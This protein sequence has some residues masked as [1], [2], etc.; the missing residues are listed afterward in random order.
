MDWQVISILFA[1][2]CSGHIMYIVGKKQGI[3]KTLDDLKADGQID[4][5]DD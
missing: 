3:S 2:A 1:A 5:D 4:F